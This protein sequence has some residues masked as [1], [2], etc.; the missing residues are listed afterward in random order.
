MS[1]YARLAAMAVTAM[2]AG[3]IPA[4]TALGS[5]GEI[6]KASTN[7][8]GSQAEVAGSVTW[9][10]CEHPMP[11]EPPR[12][13]S[14]PGEPFQ[15]IGWVAPP[16]NWT[17]FATL[18]PGTV[19]T[20]CAA[21]GRQDLD[22]LGDGVT[23]IWRGAVRSGPGTDPFDVAGIPLG[24]GANKLVCLSAVELGPVAMSVVCIQVVGHDCPA[25][26]YQAAE[27]PHALAASLLVSPPAVEPG[28]VPPV[29]VPAPKRRKHCKKNKTHGKQHARRATCKRSR[30]AKT[31]NGGN[32]RL[33]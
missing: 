23:L 8:G 7:A 3:A 4:A 10:G 27:F 19:A 20:D 29:P 24:G 30:H 16:C 25:P 26:G 1:G 6:T 13:P 11:L 2:V 9:S 21:P 31:P 17:P 15:P 28:P 32:A 18:G 22:S 5:S 12:F 14:K 33:P